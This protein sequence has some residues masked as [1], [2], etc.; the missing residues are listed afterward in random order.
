[1]YVGSTGFFGLIQYLVCPVALLLGC[2]PTRVAVAVDDDGFVVEADVALTIERMTSGRFVPFEE[3][4]S[5]SPG[6][7]F[8]G[9]VLN[10]LSE[11]LTVEV[12]RADR[13]E[14]LTFRRG[15]RE[16]HH[17]S[18]GA[19]AG[20]TTTLK[21]K[22]DASIF[23]VTSLSPE[24]FKSYLR[25]LSFL[26]RGVRF[27][28]AFGGETHEFHAERGIVDLFHAVSAPYQT[29]HEPI[30]F[31]AE[32]GPLRLEAAFAYQSW[33]ERAIWCYIN[34]GRAV[35]GGTHEKGLDRCVESDQQENP[36]FTNGEVRSQ[37][38]SSAWFRFNT[39]TPSGKAASRPGSA[40]PN[41]EAW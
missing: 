16:A 40:I 22:P 34:N 37:T 35:E 11:S 19:S 1:M 28:I 20:P 2:R 5:P 14:A 10:A 7:A 27:S 36:V 8:E 38:G 18:S 31:V 39:R 26:H 23:T 21:F 30:Q 9:A 6:H 17:E 41:S 29:L 12:Q 32:D 13:T 33:T 25:R 3:T 15:V 4:S 24:V